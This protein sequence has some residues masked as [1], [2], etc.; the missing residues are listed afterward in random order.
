MQVWF[1]KAQ[2]DPHVT[3]EY[4][5]ETAVDHHEYTYVA[6]CVVTLGC[7]DDS[8]GFVSS[9][10]NNCDSQIIRWLQ[11][12]AGK[13]PLQPAKGTTIEDSA[14]RLISQLVGSEI[15][16]RFDGALSRRWRQ[17]NEQGARYCV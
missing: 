9:H 12:Q 1:E 4:M 17:K 6:L 2:V 3:L 11:V 5:R 16:W 14:E 8:C 7:N 10:N 13:A 15:L